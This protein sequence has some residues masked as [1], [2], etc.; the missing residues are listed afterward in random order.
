MRA[1][2]SLSEKGVTKKKMEEARINPAVL[3]WNWRHNIKS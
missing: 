1:K 2:F 3:K